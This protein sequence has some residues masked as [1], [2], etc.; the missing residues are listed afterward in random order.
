M[1]KEFLEAAQRELEA[2]GQELETN[3]EATYEHDLH[4]FYLASDAVMIITQLLSQ[5]E[6]EQEVEI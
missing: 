5:I 1:F 6:Q 4:R 2:A 3:L